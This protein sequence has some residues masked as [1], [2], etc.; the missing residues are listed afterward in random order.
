MKEELQP[1]KRYSWHISLPDPYSYMGEWQIDTKREDSYTHYLGHICIELIKISYGQEAEIGG[2]LVMEG[3]N[4]TSLVEDYV[5]CDYKRYL[6]L[7]FALKC[8]P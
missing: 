5:H 7:G 1:K 3:A 4:I 2:E 6:H 8:D